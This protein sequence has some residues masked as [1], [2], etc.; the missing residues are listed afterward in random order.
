MEFSVFSFWFRAVQDAREN[1]YAFNPVSPKFLNHRHH[2]PSRLLAYRGCYES[3]PPLSVTGQSL[4]G[5]LA[6]VHSLHFRFH[7]SSP[8]S[9]RSTTLPLSLLGP[10]DCNFGDGADI[11]AQN[12]PN[13]ASSLPGDDGLHILLLAPCQQCFSD[14]GF[15]SSF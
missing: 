12:V 4:N 14:D 7:S 15:F 13:P 1:P 11:L 3:P 2:N 10:V 9:L 5:A 6:V 8:G